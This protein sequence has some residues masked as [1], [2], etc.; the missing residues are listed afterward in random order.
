[1]QRDLQVKLHNGVTG[2]LGEGPSAGASGSTS[3]FGRRS[4][5]RK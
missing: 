4:S 1:M 2:I 5:G 3:T